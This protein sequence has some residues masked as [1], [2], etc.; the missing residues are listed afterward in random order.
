[1]RVDRECH[2][3]LPSAQFSSVVT[4]A[5]TWSEAEAVAYLSTADCFGF[6]RVMFGGDRPVSEFAT[7]YQRCIG[8]IGV[9]AGT[10]LNEMTKIVLRQRD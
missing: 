4:A 8:V 6:G 1:M 3:G 7:S 9:S 2:S 10:S 5:A